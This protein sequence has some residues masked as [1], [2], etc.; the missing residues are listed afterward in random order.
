MTRRIA[1]LAALLAWSLTLTTHAATPAPTP[2]T[3]ER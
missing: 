1:R 2:D 3:T